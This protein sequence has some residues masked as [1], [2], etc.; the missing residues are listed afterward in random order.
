MIIR[1]FTKRIIPVNRNSKYTFL[2]GGKMPT[3]KK[4]IKD[5][6][7]KDLVKELIARGNYQALTSKWYQLKESNSFLDTDKAIGQ[8]DKLVE[9]ENH[10][11]NGALEH[12]DTI[13]LYEELS[14]LVSF[15]SGAYEIFGRDDRRDWYEID[16]QHVKRNAECVVGICHE[17][18]L[19]NNGDGFST[20]I[21]E[22]Y[23]DRSS[24]SICERYRDQPVSVGLFYN[25][26]LVTGDVV[27]T[28]GHR[29]SEFTK[30]T[31]LRFVSGY[32]MMHFAVPVI[33][34]PNENIYS[35]LEV[36]DPRNDRKKADW[37]L[38]RLDRE[39]IGKEIV[40]FPKEKRKIE[41]EQDVYV[42]GHP[43]GLPLKYAP[44][45]KVCRNGNP[46]Y[47][48]ANLDTSM[49]N[50][51]SPVFN[52]DHEVEGILV[53]SPAD[54]GGYKPGDGR[55]ITSFPDNC[56]SKEG[57]ARVTRFTEFI[58]KINEL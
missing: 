30:V 32:K 57:G 16:D 21:V 24:L 33:R 45:A 51:G 43:R 19:I 36:I 28:A 34:I 8:L 12:L 11:H 53:T 20:L 46:Y 41:D 38:V 1:N 40:R 37:A 56:Q 2:K 14:F 48:E 26:F 13:H 5:C 35:G 42:I 22:R 25:G 49:G 54:H 29:I 58:D 50:S 7:L 27:A 4:S 15:A 52:N 55:I 31:D 39:I 17:Q 10:I 23:G 9:K 3:E 18:D 6:T 47:F 44:W